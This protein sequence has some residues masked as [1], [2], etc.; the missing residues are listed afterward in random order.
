MILLVFG[1]TE[2]CWDEHSSFAGAQVCLSLQ[3]CSATLIIYDHT[4]M[5]SNPLLILDPDI[6][7]R[8]IRNM[9]R[10]A[11][12]QQL[13]FRPHCKTHQS[14]AIG[15]W[16]RDEGV[17]AITVSS[18]PMAAYFIHH[19]WK[20]ITIALP[21]NPMAVEEINRLSPHARI[22]LLIDHADVLAAVADLL[23]GSHDFWIKVDNGYG[24]AGIPSTKTQE[25]L[26]LAGEIR[27][28]PKHRFAGILIH[29]GDHYHCHSRE[30]LTD[31][32]R[33]NMISLEPLARELKQVF[34]GA[35]V[36]WGDTPSCSV[37]DDFGVADEIRPGNFVFYD[38]MQV[39]AGV[40]SVDDVA[41]TLAAPVL[42]VYPSEEKMLIHAGAVHLSKEKLTGTQ[43][44]DGYG[45]VTRMKGTGRGALLPQLKLHQISQEHGI[46]NGPAELLA[47]FKPG[48]LA[49]IIPVH[50]CLT[51]NLMKGYHTTMGENIPMMPSPSAITD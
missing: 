31:A 22:N 15:A 1:F 24:R 19:G 13:L 27:R 10:K 14:A 35:L 40:C 38:M 2:D 46:V 11:R 3:T 49:G 12:D 4:M 20:D 43:K 33:Q 17:T 39:A 45:L 28:H 47:T 29:Q 42:S 9:A 6:C 30:A 25:I 51:A 34:P 21:L 50:A 7:R 5:T 16:F 23:N 41:V 48:D 37:A 32:H 18:V 8:N 26:A 36:S 44:W